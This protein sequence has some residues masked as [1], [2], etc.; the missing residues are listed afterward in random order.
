MSQAGFPF[1]FTLDDE[2]ACVERELDFRK[3]V[4]PRLVERRK[5]TQAGS[6]REQACMRQVRDRLLRLRQRGET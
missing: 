6:E 3:R 5:M 1:P 2:I 4:Y